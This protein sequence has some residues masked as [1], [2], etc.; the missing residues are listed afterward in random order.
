MCWEIVEVRGWKR[1]WDGSGF[2]KWPS[3][4]PFLNGQRDETCEKETGTGDFGGRGGG[5]RGDWSAGAGAVSNDSA[6]YSGSAGDRGM[7][8]AKAGDYLAAAGDLRAYL[9]RYPDDVEALRAFAGARVKVEDSK[10]GYLL[11]AIDALRRATD[12]K[13][14]D[15]ESQHKLVDMFVQAN[16]NTECVAARRTSCWIQNPKDT[17]ALHARAMALAHLRKYDDS[18]AAMEKYIAIKPGEFEAELIRLELTSRAHPDRN[19]SEIAA[20]LQKANPGEMKWKVLRSI[21]CSAG[22]DARGRSSGRW[23]R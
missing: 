15:M 14:D 20:G 5:G 9:G 13:P 2:G 10:G 8:E 7:Q 23:R 4:T 22:G 16:M 6:Q 3:E 18:L 19:V 12:I 21:A 17:V 11:E 1:R